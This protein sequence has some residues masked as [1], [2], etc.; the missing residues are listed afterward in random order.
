[1]GNIISNKTLTPRRVKINVVVHS[2][3]GEPVAQFIDLSFK[4]AMEVLYTLSLSG[5]DGKKP[6]ELAFVAVPQQEV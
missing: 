6:H 5:F 2:L 3:K 1:M 4:R